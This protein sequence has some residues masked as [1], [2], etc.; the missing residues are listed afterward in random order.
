MTVIATSTSWPEVLITCA[1]VLAFAGLL[2][3]ARRR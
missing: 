1:V 2:K 3:L